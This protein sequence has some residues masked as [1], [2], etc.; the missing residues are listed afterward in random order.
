MSNNA[1]FAFSAENLNLIGLSRI[2]ADMGAYLARHV[3]EPNKKRQRPAPAASR[4]AILAA[5]NG[6]AYCLSKAKGFDPTL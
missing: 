2:D 5:P 3:G 4:R 6:T 1:A